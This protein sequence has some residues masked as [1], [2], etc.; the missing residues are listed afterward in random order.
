MMDLKV[1]SAYNL[2][3]EI[4]GQSYFNHSSRLDIFMIDVLLSN[5]KPD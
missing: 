3:W 2:F 1:S 4:P 5:A